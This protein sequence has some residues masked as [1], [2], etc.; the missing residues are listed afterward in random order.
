[1]RWPAYFIL[2][3]LMLGLQLGLGGFLSVG[4]VEPNLVLLVIVFIAMNAP[5]DEALIGAMMLGAMHDLVTL[6]P[7][8]LYA[9]AYGL[10]A[11][12]LVAVAQLVERGHLLAHL[13]EAGVA[14]GIWA[15]VLIIHERVH[16]AGAALIGPASTLA[17]VRTPARAV[18]ASALYTVI[19]APFVLWLLQRMQTLFQFDKRRRKRGG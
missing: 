6:E 4:G 8:G 17:A 2:A 7:M 1:L 14:G 12:V 18:L 10:V 15:A 16:P 11:L 13:A 3:Y 9:F 19:L 5:R